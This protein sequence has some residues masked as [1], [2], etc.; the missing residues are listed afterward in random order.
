MLQGERD[1]NQIVDVAEQPV[2]IPE[3]SGGSE[4]KTAVLL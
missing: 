2:A 3:C 4:I 1:Q